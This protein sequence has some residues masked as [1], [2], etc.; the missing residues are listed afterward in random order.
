MVR[1]SHHRRRI[2]SCMLAALG[3]TAALTVAS[4]S[5]QAAPSMYKVQ[6]GDTLWKISQTYHVSMNDIIAWNHLSNPNL[7]YPG[8]VL[9]LVPPQSTTRQEIVSY[10]KQFQGAPYH[11]G[12]TSART[13]F[14]CSGFVMTVYQHFGISL[15]RTAAQQHGVGEPVAKSA[16][17]PAD[18]VF[19]N[20]TG[21]PYSHVGIYIGGGQFIS[22]TT[23][24]GVTVSNLNDPYYWA[25]RFTAATDP[26][27]G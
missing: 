11:W 19:F 23:S 16:L 21:Q 10:A 27:A 12:G 26:L 9:T 7:I 2:Q 24:K 14:D 5:A 22:A 17:Q 8:Q 1:L 13:G 4:V 20:T 15:P 18:L 3:A 25:A 6:P